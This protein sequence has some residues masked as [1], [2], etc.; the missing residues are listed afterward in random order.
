MSVVF[1]L[2]KQPP[3][4]RVEIYQSNSQTFHRPAGKLDTNRNNK[5]TCINWWVLIVVGESYRVLCVCGCVCACVLV[6]VGVS[7]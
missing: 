7:V 2:T 3:L 4:F 5:M 1:A 6:C